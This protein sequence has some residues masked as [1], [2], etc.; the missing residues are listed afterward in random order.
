MTAVLFTVLFAGPACSDEPPTGDPVEAL[1]AA[2][3]RPADDELARTALLTP[4]A[5]RL[6]APGDLGRA[7]LLEEWRDEDR[8]YPLANADLEVRDKVLARFEEQLRKAMAGSD[9]A[10]QQA[11]AILIGDI[12]VRARAGGGAFDPA[13][14]LGR[15]QVREHLAELAHGLIKLSESND[16]AVRMAAI[17]ALGKVQPEPVTAVRAIRRVLTSGQNAGGERAAAAAALEELMATAMWNRKEVRG[18]KAEQAEADRDLAQVGALVLSA[19]GKWVE[20]SNLEVRHPC[21]RTI[22]GAASVLADLAPET[23]PLPAWGEELVGFKFRVQRQ[24]ESLNPL[25]DSLNGVLPIVATGLTEE[26]LEPDLRAPACEVLRASAIARRRLQAAGW[27][28]GNVRDPLP[29]LPPARFGP[30]SALKDP[31]P[32]VR[33]I[34]AEALGEIGVSTMDLVEKLAR[35]SHKDAEAQVRQA[36]MVALSKMPDDLTTYDVIDALAKGLDDRHQGVR[37]GASAGLLERATKY[38]N[39]VVAGL[40]EALKGT[41]GRLTALK[42]L[43]TIGGDARKAIPETIAAMDDANPAIRAAA[44]VAL[45]RYGKP[46]EAARDALR[47]ALDDPDPG[48]RIAAAEALLADK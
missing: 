27:A 7:L 6:T 36:A 44:A 31:D 2:L 41:N 46:G 12:A 4:L 5:D 40:T 11:A 9:P 18:S 37:L 23:P 30:V 33:T 21:W 13:A 32:K 38:P 35:L 17:R 14:I 10:P 3:K 26:K 24:W 20:D 42:A 19:T 45:G 47:K 34:A 29:A 22:R 25:I 43:A 1:R 15:P 16:L 8:K 39:E 28:A 48:V